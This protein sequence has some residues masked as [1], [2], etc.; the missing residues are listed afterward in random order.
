[1]VSLYVKGLGL[2][3]RP[4][5]IEK[6]S[7]C[8]RLPRPRKRLSV[9]DAVTCGHEVTDEALVD[10]VLRNDEKQIVIDEEELLSRFEMRKDVQVGI[11]SARKSILIHD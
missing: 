4:S 8:V 6:G 5:S 1:M 9:S 2:S 11:V 10:I 3:S 7:C